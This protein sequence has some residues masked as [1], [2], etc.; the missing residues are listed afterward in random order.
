[1]TNNSKKQAEQLMMALQTVCRA[2]ISPHLQA[3]LDIQDVDVSQLWKFIQ[4]H[5]L[6]AV[7]HEVSSHQNFGLPPHFMARLKNRY[8]KQVFK[9]LFIIQEL[10]SIQA[11]HELQGILLIP[12]KGIAIG[13]LF[14]ND[15]NQRDFGDID[16]A[17]EEENIPASAEIMRELGYAELKEE[18]N[19]E[20]P[21]DSRSYHIDYAWV[22]KSPN[23]QYA[24]HAEIHW[25]TTNSALYSP[26]QFSALE[27]KTEKTKVGNTEIILFSKVE[28]AYLMILHHGIVDGWFELRH[29]V[30][31]VVTLKALSEEEQATLK[32]RLEETKLLTSFHYGVQLCR[33]I[34]GVELG[35]IFVP[36]LRNY[37][38]YLKAVQS[39]SLPGK[40]SENKSKLYYYLLLHDN[41][42]E[43]IKSIKKF[44][45]FT[46]RD[47]KFK[48]GK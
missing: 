35:Q 42:T 43:R 29:L 47:M 27:N 48:F 36:S 41:H 11:A 15:V 39:G 24:C 17:I 21:K 38:K 45:R 37:N 18:S 23:G 25:Q 46:L 34:L 32:T 1:M 7:L 40:W 12:Y 19:F 4:K 13:E 44:F 14:Y 30:D 28:N 20:K 31:L 8:R 10:L 9:K 33:D 26:A 22:K 16:F 6:Q 5:K 3:E 2:Y